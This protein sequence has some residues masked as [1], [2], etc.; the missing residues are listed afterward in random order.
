M[1]SAYNIHI[2]GVVQGVGFRPFVYRL[3][4][5]YLING[6]VLNAVDGVHIYAEG[7]EKLLDEFILE[8]ANSAPPAA[9][10]AEIDLQEA[11]LEFFDTFEIRFSEDEGTAD[12]TEVS[13]DLATCED[14]E[15]ELFDPDNRRYRYPFINCTNCG[16]R[17]T[18]I[19]ELPYDRAST[20][21][22]DFTMCEQCQAEYDDPLNR[23]FHAQPNACFE[24]GPHIYIS[25]DQ[26]R[27]LKWGNSLEE[28]NAVIAEAVQLLLDGKI[29]AIK[30]L[31]GFHLACN[32]AD[33]AAIA[34]LRER[35]H[36]FG[37]P[38]A[39][40]AET[41]DNVRE[42][43]EVN[44]AEKRLLTGSARPI[45]LLKKKGGVTFADGLADK[46]T[47]LGVMLPYTP[48]QHILLRDFSEAFKKQ[49][50]GADA[51]TPILVMTSGNVHDE[52][53]VIDDEVAFSVLGDIADA[54]LG[55]DRRILT[56]FDDS[57]ARVIKAGSAGEAVQM[58]RRAR[59][60][61]PAQIKV[62]PA[63]FTRDG[64]AVSGDTSVEAA[65]EETSHFT[66]F[67][68]GPEQKN[69]FAFLKDDK[70]YVSQHIGDVENAD[71]FE[72]WHEAK[73]RYEKLFDLHADLLAC[74]L[75]PEY[76]TSKWAHEQAGLHKPALAIEQVQH[77]HAHIVS[78]IAE[79]ALAGPVCGIAFD[80][81]GYGPDGN[82][83]GGEV[84]VANAYDYERFANLAYVPMPGGAS[85]I[86]HP[87]QMAYGVLWEFDLLEHPAAVKALSALGDDRLTSLDTMIDEGIN[88]PI[89]SSAGRLF[90]AASALLG[91]CT[92]PAYE[93]EP[94]ILLEAAMASIEEEDD[95]TNAYTI[96]VIKNVAN[97]TSTA[98]DT[99][100]VLLD[101][102]HAF[103]KML[104]D[105]EAGVPVPVI[106]RRFHDAFVGA[107]V[108]A[109]SLANALYEI[110]TVVLS[111]GVFMNRYIIEHSIS[112]L[113]QAGFTV[114]L[115]REL[116]PN[117]GC[118]SFGEAVIAYANAKLSSEE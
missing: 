49:S 11:P 90:D 77:H 18:I 83:W 38:F 89:T 118:I 94:A 107:I 9:H 81:T 57:V 106:A 73:A 109:A 96:D 39:V 99:S 74:D 59:G 10:V 67:A 21:M 53:I 34:R 8:L 108:T 116:P 36:R 91:I 65:S 29:V 82:I 97:E 41:L 117:D 33:P 31:G 79:N 104:D 15:R 26:G 112:A 44:A 17:F 23:R 92:Q 86:K 19:D 12:P 110:K 35:K 78:A 14:C 45:V 84:L 24:C 54:Y 111:G 52:P 27:S 6:W 85:A 37:K 56:R 4:K 25:S 3:A 47:E 88:T 28:S 48:L 46:L 87:L 61:A 7:D 98:H 60:Y 105:M 103:E 40:M 62:D 50:N 1:N 113:E 2:K 68:A 32:A 63:I 66:I 80:G 64:E 75:H 42:I 95:S 102:K 101:S 30:G 20:S 5:R 55:N 93:G 58:I 43:C 71:T 16:P 13:P 70:S 115:N 51:V 76:I 72:A 69:T 114:A 22:A 100:V